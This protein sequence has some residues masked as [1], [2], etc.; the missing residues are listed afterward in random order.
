MSKCRFSIQGRRARKSDRCLPLPGQAK[1]TV[2]SPSAQPEVFYN[3]RH[4]ATPGYHSPVQFLQ[5]WIT[6]QHEQKMA[7]LERS[8]GRRK[9]DERSC[10]KAVE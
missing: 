4:P 8:P 9:T 2:I 1:L 6:N 5:D 7:A 10:P 3:R